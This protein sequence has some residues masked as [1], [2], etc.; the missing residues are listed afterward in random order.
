MSDVALSV[1]DLSP[2]SDGSTVAA[3]LQSSLDLAAHVDALG[4]HRSW[5][6]D[7]HNIPCIASSSP[8]FHVVIG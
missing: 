6:A 1:L 2:V 8:K 4:Y 3:A 5:V 7:H